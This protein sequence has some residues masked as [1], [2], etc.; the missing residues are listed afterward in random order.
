MALPINDGYT[1]KSQVCTGAYVALCAKAG[2]N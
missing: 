2:V 1:P